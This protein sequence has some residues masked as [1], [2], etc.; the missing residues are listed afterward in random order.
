MSSRAT[1][2]NKINNRL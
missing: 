2:D 1:K